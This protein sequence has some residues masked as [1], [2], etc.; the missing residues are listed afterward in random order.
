[1]VEQ[2]H[3]LIYF[4]RFALLYQLS[5]EVIKKPKKEPS[6]PDACDTTIP[7]KKQPFGEK[8]YEGMRVPIFDF[9]LMLR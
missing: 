7:A 1:M 2:N 4:D 6:L 8:I 3:V 9:D 5:K